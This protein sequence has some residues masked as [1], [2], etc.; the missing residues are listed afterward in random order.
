MIPGRYA[1]VLV[2]LACGTSFAEGSNDVDTLV[3]A[4]GDSIALYNIYDDGVL[5]SSTSYL[6]SPGFS[7]DL[8]VSE[9]DRYRHGTSTYFYKNGTIRRRSHWRDGKA[10]AND[11]VWHRN[12]RIRFITTHDTANQRHGLLK[13]YDKDGNLE[14]EKTYVHGKLSGPSR[15]YYPSG[16]KRREGS[17]EDD[18]KSGWWR[19]W[20]KS[21]VLRDSIRYVDD[22]DVDIYRYFEN[23]KLYMRAYAQWTPRDRGIMQMRRLLVDTYSPEGNLVSQ[24][25][26]GNGYYHVYEED[27]TYKGIMSIKDGLPA[28]FQ[29]EYSSVTGKDDLVATSDPRYPPKEIPKKQRLPFD[30]KKYG[31]VP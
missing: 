12:G 31:L 25:R 22:H 8:S 14:E 16:K 28:Q 3:N 1:I 24:L 5:L 9:R 13:F 19:T 18:E 11:T 23:G 6:L 15:R 21:G 20:Y 27:G 4:D 17:F 26:N 2:F 7:L 30:V 29:D 10:I